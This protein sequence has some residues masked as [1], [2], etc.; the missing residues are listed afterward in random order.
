MFNA[1][2]YPINSPGQAP[3]AAGGWGF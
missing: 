1:K 3:R 2:S